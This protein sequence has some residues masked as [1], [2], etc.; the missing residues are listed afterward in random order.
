MTDRLQIARET[1]RAYESGDRGP[2]DEHLGDDF[3]FSSPADVGIDR[4][5]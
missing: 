3:T 4:A 2:L 1:Y 5:T